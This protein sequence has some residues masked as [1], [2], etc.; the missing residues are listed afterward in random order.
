MKI[1]YAA[2]TFGHIRSF[3]V[4]YIK[5]MIARGHEVDIA[6]SGVPDGMPE[7]ANV[8]RLDF[9]KKMQSPVN[10]KTARRLTEL[11]KAKK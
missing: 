7:G 11:M 5:E 4:P 1:L 10:F 2:S 9:E 6:G 3:H 8:I